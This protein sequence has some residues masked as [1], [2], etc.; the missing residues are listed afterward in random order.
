M[1]S[2]L[3]VWTSVTLWLFSLMSMCLMMALAKQPVMAADWTDHWAKAV[4]RSLA[5]AVLTGVA[6]AVLAL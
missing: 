3:L 4:N 5:G 6:C 1:F 2:T